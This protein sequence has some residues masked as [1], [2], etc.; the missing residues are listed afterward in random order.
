MDLLF[1][2]VMLLTSTV[3]LAFIIE[4]GFALRWNRVLPRGI[5]DAAEACRTFY[6]DNRKAGLSEAV[7]GVDSA[8]AG[9]DNRDIANFFLHRHRSPRGCLSDIIRKAGS[10]AAAQFR[11]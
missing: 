10:T 3:G 1:R 5:G 9:A 2:I 11:L 6:A 8:E 4:R 7:R